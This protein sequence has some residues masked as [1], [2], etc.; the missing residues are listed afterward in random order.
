MLFHRIPGIRATNFLTG[1]SRTFAIAKSG[2][3]IDWPAPS[4][5]LNFFGASRSEA[6]HHDGDAN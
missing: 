5:F 6:R 4:L 2:A 3:M 1:H